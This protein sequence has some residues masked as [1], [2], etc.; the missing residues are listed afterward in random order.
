ME[1]D[2]GFQVGENWFRYR[3]GAVII[4]NGCALFVSNRQENYYYSVGGAV[5]MN[6]R[7]EH[8]VIREVLEE[9]GIQ[10]EIDRLIVIHEN[11]FA[12]SEGALKNL[13]CHEVSFYYLM[14]PRG[15]QEL[16]GGGLNHFGEQEELY[17]LP[18]ETLDTVKAYPSFLKRYLANPSDRIVHIITEDNTDRIYQ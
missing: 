13:R 10:Y 18:I 8:A 5:H 3:V 15:T 7:A 16:P 4:E 12:E 6:E 14:K 9:T 2:C 17:W 11:F 1:L